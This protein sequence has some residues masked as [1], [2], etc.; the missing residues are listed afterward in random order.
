M[1]PAPAAVAPAAP[2]WVVV[3]TESSMEH[4]MTLP[5]PTI[6][7]EIVTQL[8]FRMENLQGTFRRDRLGKKAC[9]CGP[10]ARVALVLPDRARKQLTSFVREVISLLRLESIAGGRIVV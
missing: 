2:P 5:A 9:S 10:R 1:P 3:D 7:N 6:K 8:S 4:P